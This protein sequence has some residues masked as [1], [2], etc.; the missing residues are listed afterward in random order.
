MLFQDGEGAV[1]C[2]K[3]LQDGVLGVRSQRVRKRGQEE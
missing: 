2:V 1:E 3:V